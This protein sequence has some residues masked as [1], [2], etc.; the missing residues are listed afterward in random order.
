MNVCCVG[1]GYIGLPTAAL[2]A[3]A[4]VKVTGVDTD[5][6]VVEKINKGEVHIAE[7]GL[8]AMVEKSVA[9]SWL[10]ASVEIPKA[11]VFVIAVPTP[12]LSDKSP[13]MS[14]V[15]DV[16]R[17]IAPQLEKNNLLILESTSPVGTL[18]I[19]ADIIMAERHKL[20]LDYLE[21]RSESPD[22]FLAYCPERVLPGN[23]FE[24]LVNND[25][26]IGGLCR[27]SAAR[28]AEFYNSFIEGQCFQTDS[29]SAELTKLVENSYRD[30]NIAFANELSLIADK[31]NVDIWDLINLA[32]K[33]PRVN[34]LEPGPG[35]G[36]HC[37]AV[38]PWFIVN[39][40]PQEARLIREARQVNDA[41]PDFI[42]RKVMEKANLNQSSVESLV[43]GCFGLSFKA[44]VG[45]TRES[46]ALK[47]I[48][49]LAE[50]GFK[51]VLVSDPF[52]KSLPRR[53]AK[54]P[55][56]LKDPQETLEQSDIVVLLVDHEDF[57]NLKVPNRLKNWV[58]DTRGIW[59]SDS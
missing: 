45:D 15:F 26:V 9:N 31:L 41:K 46:P 42:V 36:G 10:E 17:A 59:R 37:I 47:I 51:G 35:V 12:F 14:S 39:S 21:I 29:K 3:S 25:R 27:E 38:D 8:K 55:I 49:A 52:F 20:D 44:N 53:I 58:I 32:N 16:A 11:D 34:I 57:K 7:P 28:A 30:V 22:I 6:A 24:E 50:Y 43:L 13:D 33:H 23:I 54:D 4:G 2:I 5:L 56:V 18:E 19:F 48:E 1:L 40:A